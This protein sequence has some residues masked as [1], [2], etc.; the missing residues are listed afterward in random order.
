MYKINQLLLIIYIEDNVYL[1]YVNKPTAPK[2]KIYQK[3]FAAVL[4]IEGTKY[5]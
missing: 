3:A 2:I 4:M 5:F 1:I